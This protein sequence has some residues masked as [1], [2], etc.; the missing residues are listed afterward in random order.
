[1]W[2]VSS[3]IILE[4][5]LLKRIMNTLCCEL[6]SLVENISFVPGKPEN[7]CL[8]IVSILSLQPDSESKFGCIGFAVSVFF[9]LCFFSG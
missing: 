1:L 3:C 9:Y 8:Y 5:L 6:S 2:M 4:I 7:I